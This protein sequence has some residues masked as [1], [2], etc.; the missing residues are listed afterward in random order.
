LPGWI[1]IRSAAESIR[2]KGLSVPDCEAISL[3]KELGATLLLTDDR[4]ARRVAAGL[5]LAT[6]GTLGLL[7]VGAQRGI[8]SL[9]AALQKLRA[10]SCFLTEELIESALQRDR[11]R[12]T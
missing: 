10:T 1:E 7:E 9:S 2:A 12:K 5:G 8:V 11:D 4:Q 6:M 3:A